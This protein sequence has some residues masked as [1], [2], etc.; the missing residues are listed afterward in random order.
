V[1]D[2]T[3]LGELTERLAEASGQVATSI[4]NAMNDEQRAAVAAALTAGARIQLV[5]L[6]NPSFEVE[7]CLVTPGSLVKVARYIA[8]KTPTNAAVEKES[9]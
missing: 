6:L 7:F 9:E 1:S 8:A 4:L 2:A 5:T 3:G